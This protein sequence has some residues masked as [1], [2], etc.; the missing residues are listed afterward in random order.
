M[1]FLD[2]IKNRQAQQQSAKQSPEQQE[3]ETAKEM[4]TRE[5][6]QERAG[7]K[8]MQQMPPEQQ[9]KVEE[10]K[11][12][13][14]QATQHLGQNAE[15]FSPAPADSAASPQPMAQKMMS[16]ENAAHALSPTSAQAGIRATEQNVPSSESSGKSQEQSAQAPRKTIARTTPSWER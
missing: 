13:L 12:K 3:P 15:T 2:F 7:A 6:G 10:V 11:G 16:Q 14:Q 5:S 4:Y 8:S 1:A 9:A